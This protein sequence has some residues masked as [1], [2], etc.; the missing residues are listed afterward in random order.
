[1]CKDPNA[2]ICDEE[3][4]LKLLEAACAFGRDDPRELLYRLDELETKEAG[5]VRKVHRSIARLLVSRYIDITP[6]TPSS[7]DVQITRSHASACW[8]RAPLLFAGA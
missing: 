3:E 6:V 2:V 4:A 1:M 7:L 5:P 8:D